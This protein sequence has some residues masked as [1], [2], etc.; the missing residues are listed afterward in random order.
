MGS[1]DFG[2]QFEIRRELVAARTLLEVLQDLGLPGPHPRPVRVEVKRVGVQMRL[3]IAGQTRIR[4]DP[5]GA[6]DSVFP[7]EDGEVAKAGLAQEDTQR[8]PARTRADDADRRAQP[9]RRH[10]PPSTTSSAPVM[11]DAWSDTRNA[12]TF[13]TSTGS[14]RRPNVAVSLLWVASSSIGVAIG[15]GNTAFTRIPSP[16]S[17]VAAT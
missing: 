2:V 9:I 14:P 13:A 16:A 15:P 4:I 3:H 11:N 5:P 6:A 7:V 8:Q 1:S 10:C 12:T 17:S